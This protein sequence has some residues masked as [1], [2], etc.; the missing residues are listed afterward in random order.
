MNFSKL[1]TLMLLALG[2]GAALLSQ[3]AQAAS[4][5]DGDVFLG[6]R[7]TGG[8]G[9][10]KDYMINLGP[11]SQF[12]PTATSV[13][14]PA[15]GSVGDDLKFL[16]G[17]SWAT[18]TDVY[19][20]VAGTTG[21]SP[22]GS[23]P[24][25]T[26]Y[27]TNP[28]LTPG[29][30]STPW[31]RNSTFTQGGT[32]TLMEGMATTFDSSP[33]TGLVATNAV[34]QDN[35]SA[36][37]WG[38]YQ[39]GGANAGN[40]NIA[41]GAFNPSIENT[42]TGGAAT[43]FLDLYRV[44]PSTPTFP[45]GTP[46]DYLGVLVLDGN[47]QLSFIPKAILGA[48]SLAFA[49]TS[50]SVAE[51]V[52]GGTLTLNITRSGDPTLAGSVTVSTID[53]TAS[54][55]SSLDFTAINQTVSFASGDV[56]KSVTISITNRHGAA[57]SRNFAVHLSN[58]SQGLSVGGDATVTITA[59]ITP[60][61][62]QLTSATFTA[63]QADASVDITLTRTG[64]T[65]AESVLIST[66]DGSGTGGAKAGTDFTGLTNATVSF[67]SNATT[68]TQTVALSQPVGGQPNKTFTVT[69][70]GP[71][72]NVTLGT[73]ATAT[74]T[75]LASDN[76]V[77]TV[78]ISSP[79]AA[80]TITASSVTL[81]GMA[82]DNNQ[83]AS[84]LVSIN[85]HA[86]V[87]ASLGSSTIL[88]VPW[89]LTTTTAAAQGL[90]GGLNNVQVIAVDGAGNQ[91]AV[92]SVSFTLI[93]K[94]GL[95]AITY[96]GANVSS[97]G[98]SVAGLLAGTTA[99]Q[100]GKAYT[101]TAKPA[102]GFV[103]DHWV[104]PGVP[105][106][107]T[108]AAISF[109]YTDAILAAPT[110]KAY[111]VLN[112]FVAA[113]IGAYNGLL[114]PHAGTTASTGTVGFLNVTVT[115]TG[116]FTGSLKIGD[117]NTGLTLGTANGLTGI[118][119]TSGD[120][121][122]NVSRPNDSALVVALH[123]DLT[124]NSA[125]ITGTVKQ[126]QRS[127][128]VA[129]SDVLLDRANFS[130]TIP[131][132]ANYLVN[133]GSYTVVLPAKTQPNGSVLTTADC[134]QGTGCG[135]IAIT[136][137][138]NVTFTL[139]LADGT[140]FIATAPLSKGLTVA[141][142][143]QLYTNKAGSISGLVTLN[144][145]ATDSDLKATNCMWFRPWTGAQY[146]PWGWNE[147]VSIDLLGAKYNSSGSAAGA[148]VVPGLT[149][150]AAPNSLLTFSAGSLTNNVTK[151]ANVS[152]TNLVT[153]FD[154]TDKSFSLVLTAASGKITGTFPHSDGTTPA[155][156]GTVFQKGPLS[157]GRGFFLTTAPKVIDGTG[158]SGLMTLTPTVN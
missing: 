135:T 93:E 64:G 6:V 39:P 151:L 69:L 9:S 28:Q 37:C 124:G 59:Q 108:T 154:S 23:V 105:T 79:A 68:A 153:K 111:F 25:K 86:Q 32:T 112:P 8:I 87:A 95:S 107:S 52:A 48:S 22:V 103:F 70:S 81:S 16:F 29:T 91:S 152:P 63:H 58:A 101:A 129:T 38:S 60:S 143:S 138:G 158:T 49:S 89:N 66:A 137:A 133:K 96:V 46:A 67:P 78:S 61:V 121:T 72:T 33:S 12:D 118:F 131:V 94:G 42:F 7:A 97:S 115:A 90:Q 147:G 41:F 85:G 99:Y 13:I 149:G 141:L 62:V 34:S 128:V 54:S 53:G 148:S 43:S 44:S 126:Y 98:G 132:P 127:T 47:G 74:V 56:Q 92:A 55:S 83:V 2:T 125:Q 119:N 117:F 75:I 35:P 139:T 27:A 36:S 50:P 51:N 120:A 18:R 10:N 150:V 57:G 45:T 84:V 15:L 104:I 146:Y 142:Y 19:W 122:V 144:D 40:A 31:I 24:A 65:S 76:V 11:A 77:P 110:I 5:S 123:L 145:G 102:A 71:S 134:P 26:L 116:S 88:G 21:P 157:G 130:T 73:P 20:G 114:T 156:L 155:F 3:T 82:K 80:A 136:S 100:V 106:N 30:Q 17:T 14:K 140:A 4:H 109:V 1:K 113:K